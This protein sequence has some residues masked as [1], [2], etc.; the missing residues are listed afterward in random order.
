MSLEPGAN[1]IAISQDA[2]CGPDL[3]ETG[4]DAFMGFCTRAEGLLPP[5]FFSRI[6]GSPFD[7]ASIDLEGA[8]KTGAELAKRTHDLRLLTLLV[9]LYALDRRT[10][11]VV[12]LT[13]QIATLLDQHWEH[14]HPRAEDG[15]LSYRMSCVQSLDDNPHVIL[16]LQHS[17]LVAKASGAGLTLRAIMIAQGEIEPREGEERLELAELDRRVTDTELDRLADGQAVIARFASAVDRIRTVWLERGGYDNAVR[18]DLLTPFASKARDSVAAFLVRR[19]PELAQTLLAGAGDGAAAAT[20]EGEQQANTITGGSVTIANLGEATHAL[21]MAADYFARKEPSNPALLLIRQAE[22]LVGKSFLDVLR[23]LAPDHLAAASINLGKDTV[24]MLPVER[25]AEFSS[26]PDRE[27]NGEAVADFVAETRQQAVE[28]LGGVIRFYAVSEPS[29][30]LPMFLE[31]A[32]ALA[33]RDFLGILKDV[34]PGEA[35]QIVQK[36][37]P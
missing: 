24:L 15:D 30:P 5:S 9:K 16:P 8:C 28:L 23:V 29:S 7:R 19:K 34:L 37:D 21:S 1:S 3:F 11:T 33:G 2:P 12:A 31:R 35:L 32:R 17:P 26:V 36:D 13:E 14:V 20:G 27:M 4:D 18:F 22:Q 6:D 10:E 25:F